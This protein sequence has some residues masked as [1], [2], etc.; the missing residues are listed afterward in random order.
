VRSAADGAFS[1][2]WRIHCRLCGGF[3]P[4]CRNSPPEKTSLTLRG[5]DSLSVAAFPEV[6]FKVE[7]LLG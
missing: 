6:T 3:S 5:G 2:I 1:P 7:D 4:P